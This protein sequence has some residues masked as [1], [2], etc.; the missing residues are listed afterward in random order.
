MVI[1]HVPFSED[2]S[3]LVILEAL[4][5]EKLKEILEGIAE[6]VENA[7]ARKGKPG[8]RARGAAPKRDYFPLRFYF[9]EKWFASLHLWLEKGRIAEQLSPTAVPDPYIFKK[10]TVGCSFRHT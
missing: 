5:A 3:W 1:P 4:E 2:K 8:Q 6:E 10:V 7:D 9:D